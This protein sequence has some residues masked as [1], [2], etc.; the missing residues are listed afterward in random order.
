VSAKH[1][2]PTLGLA[3]LALC[4]FG[5]AAQVAEPMPVPDLTQPELAPEKQSVLQR[6]PPPGYETLDVRLGSFILGGALDLDET[7][8]SNVFATSRN[9]RSDFITNAV[10]QVAIQSDWSNHAVALVAQGAIS[11]HAQNPA[12]DVED[13]AV[14]AEGRL[15]I[16]T[17]EYIRLDG[18]YQRLHEDRSSPEDNLGRFPTVYTVASGRLSYVRSQ[19]R[20]GFEFDANVSDYNYSN[21]PTAGGGEIINKDRDRLEASLTPRLS[22]EILPGYQTYVE[23]TGNMRQYDQKFDRSGLQRNSDGYSVATGLEAGLGHIVTG[24]AYIGYQQQSYRDP[25][26]ASFS[27]PYFGAALLWNV[28]QLTSLRFGLSDSIA[29]TILP[30]ASGIELSRVSAAIEHE[31]QRNLL[32]SGGVEYERDAY[33]GT[34]RTDGIYGAHASVVRLVNRAVSVE[35]Q[36]GWERRSSSQSG[37]DYDRET[38]MLVLKI[39]L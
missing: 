39:H 36:G 26:L 1:L 4:S 10:P 8:N 7:F 17:G 3:S 32:L 34:T 12:E 21:E 38:M 25:R 18:G 14:E 37:A 29:E 16:A 35:L 9:T 6:A 2:S 28:T 30:G 15:D 24:R 5:A 22:Y 20:V 19:S 23:V 33:Q 31:Y 11:R 13:A 27:A